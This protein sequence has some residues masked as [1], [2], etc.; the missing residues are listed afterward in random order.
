M[1][2]LPWSAVSA[3][4]CTRSEESVY[5]ANN[6]DS[7]GA[8]PGQLPSGSKDKLPGFLPQSSHPHGGT[9]AHAVIRNCSLHT[10]RLREGKSLTQS[11]VVGGNGARMGELSMLTSKSLSQSHRVSVPSI[12]PTAQPGPEPKGCFWQAPS[13]GVRAQLL[14][15]WVSLAP[16]KPTWTTSSR[17]PPG[18]NTS[19]QGFLSSPPQRS[20]TRRGSLMLRGERQRGS[21]VSNVHWQNS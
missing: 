15:Q 17:L 9:T 16:A 3:H 10:R 1:A 12:P 8:G 20:H 2:S 4:L 19:A 6:L 18:R 11:Q 13:P 14:Q 5:R 21:E 7:L